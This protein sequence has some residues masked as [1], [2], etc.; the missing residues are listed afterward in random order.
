MVKQYLKY[1]PKSKFG[2]ISSTRSNAIYDTTGQFAI[3]P[4]LEEVKLWDLKKG[5]EV[6]TLADPEIKHEVTAIACSHD[7]QY[8]VTGYFDGTIRVWDLPTRSLAIVFNGHKSEV[9]VLQFD[10]Q[11]ARLVSGSRDTDIIVWDILNETG[12]YRLRGHRNQITGLSFLGDK[13]CLISVSKDTLIKV[14][15]LTTQHCIQTIVGHRSEIWSMCIDPVKCMLV[16]GSSDKDLKLWFLHPELLEK[17]TV[18]DANVAVITHAGEIERSSKE[19]VTQLTLHSSGSYI[20][21][22]GNDKTVEVFRLRTVEEA[23]KKAMRRARRQ[24]EKSKLPEGQAEAPPNEVKLS[25]II[26]SYQMVRAAAK[27]RSFDMHPNK[28]AIQIILALT[29]N[30]VETH[31]VPLPDKEG[32]SECLY[33]LEQP[34][35][36]SDVRA[37]SLSSDDEL[38]AS[39][40]NGLLK[41]WNIQSGACI[42]TMDCGVA[43]CCTFLPGDRHIVVGTKTGAIELFDVASSTLIESFSAHSSTVWSMHVRP[44]KGG[45]VSGS[46]DKEVKFW[47][48]DTKTLVA[49]D[50]TGHITR[51]LTLTHARTLQMSDDVLCVKYSPD[52]KLLAVSLIDTTVKVFYADSLKLFLSLYGHKLPVV[53]LDIT[54]DSHLI[55]TGSADK[56]IKLWGLEFGDCHRSLFAHSESVMQVQ[57]VPNTH[58]FFSVSK[59]KQVKYWDGD[60]FENIM[61]LDGHQSEVWSLAVSRHGSFVVTGSN[62]RS[63]RVWERTDEPLF[64]EEEREKEMEELFESTLVDNSSGDKETED[65]VSRI[66]S[67]TIESL[68]AGERIFEAIAIADQERLDLEAHQKAASS[69]PKPP[70]HPILSALKVTSERYVFD[71]VRQVRPADLEDA[72]LALPFG[73]ITSLLSYIAVWAQKSWSTPLV[74]RVLTFVLKVYHPQITTSR[75]IRPILDSIRHDLRKNLQHQ[76]DTMGFNLAGLKFLQREAVASDVTFGDDA[77]ETLENITAAVKRKMVS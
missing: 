37:I 11:C 36:R 34:G 24:K 58:Y 25:D 28:G 77:P 73:K 27:I 54:T 75:S 74:A 76:K 39:C 65:E 12:L 69:E 4:C 19:R 15:D 30:S 51:Q 22:L 42:R 61:K 13:D 7:G 2:V 5:T 53:S 47:D 17:G 1:I 18:D 21:C 49:E 66:T 9:T 64:L 57:F 48:L 46:A 56:N 8:V 63:L 43:I 45:L 71:I 68:K 26:S 41:V 23:T 55:V 70:R 59:D 31:S 20:G 50:G 60:K 67:Q 38:L 6:A 3:L 52:Q 44:D 35:H 33:S 40:S 14:W 29:D 16:T 72:L 10:S 62:D 32:T